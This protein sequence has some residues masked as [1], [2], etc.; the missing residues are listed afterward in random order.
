MDTYYRVLGV[1][2]NA[3]PDEIAAAYAR[4]R[5]RY[6]ADRV[7][8][9]GD[10]FAR[11][12]TERLSALERAY[13]V[14]SDQQRRTAY[15]RSLTNG[16]TR[17][18]PPEKRAARLSRRELTALTI[19]ALAGILIIAVVWT[20]AGRTSQPTVTMAKLE[21]PAPAFELR[22]LNGQTVRLENYRDKVVMVNFWWSGCVPCVEETPALQAAYSKLAD[23]GL[24]IIGVN[25]RQNER[26]GPEGDTDVQRFVEQ[27]GVT[28]PIAL[29]DTGEVGRSYQV[30][31]LPT[32]FFI[33]QSGTIRYA[34][35]QSI[36]A[37]DV[38][39]VFTELQRDAMAMR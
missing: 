35:Y 5:E 34:S 12:A 3:S 22:D 18:A 24:V 39:R 10:E 28:Y 27:Y 30:L 36:T 21:R 11:V 6:D 7:A 13:A 9:L 26:R 25:V 15:D 16:T 4:Q 17:S 31:P 29:D 37:E 32:S 20:L 33:D 8:A 1:D 19:G 2:P 23:E 38:E 14:L